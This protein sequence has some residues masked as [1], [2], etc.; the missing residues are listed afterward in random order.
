VISLV[1]VINEELQSNQ[2]NKLKF[3]SL[4]QLCTA[5][6]LAHQR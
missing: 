2:I 4:A 3:A 5:L 6:A 1:E